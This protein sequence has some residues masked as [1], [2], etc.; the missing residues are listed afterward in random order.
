[1][2]IH[3]LKAILR[4]LNDLRM[5]QFL[6]C[7]I[8][9]VSLVQSAV[10][11]PSAR[12]LAAPA[13]AAPIAV[14]RLSDATY[15]V[16]PQY[17]FGYDVQDSLTGDS[18][19]QI[20]TRN[21]DFVQ[22]QYSLTEP[23]DILTTH[24][25]CNQWSSNCSGNERSSRSH[26]GSYKWG[27]YCHWSFSDY[28]IETIHRVCSVVHNSSSACKEQKFLFNITR[29]N[30]LVFF[31]NISTFLSDK[32]DPV[33]MLKLSIMDQ[34][35][36]YA[37][38]ASENYLGNHQGEYVK[39]DIVSSNTLFARTCLDIVQ[40]LTSTRRIV[41]YTADPVNGFNAV[42]RKAPVAVAAP[43][44]AAPVAPAAPLVARAI[45]APLIAG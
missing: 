16:N 1:M 17:S 13:V 20:E 30:C 2:S 28:S 7:F 19:A 24:L 31:N 21:G 9:L 37:L 8:G 15:D 39:Q 6:L 38:Y 25:S 43:L 44:V 40:F 18:K 42:V 32:W 11:V 45:A 36:F 34:I 10:I 12:V 23:D 3:I 41:D 29:Y 33:K 27:S 4:H 35:A 26:W 22:G 5:L 14:A